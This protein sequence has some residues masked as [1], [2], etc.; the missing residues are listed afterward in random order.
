M[1]SL[2]LAK[3][4][5]RRGKNA[6]RRVAVRLRPV[7]NSLQQLKDRHRQLTDDLRLS[8]SWNR[9]AQ[10]EN[11]QDMEC[12]LQYAG[13]LRRVEQVMR[14]ITTVG[15]VLERQLRQEVESADGTEVEAA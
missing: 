1:D 3:D 10:N 6:F 12:V 13:L 9:P 7:V 15:V 14:K 5:P 2:Q 4:R 11:R 8:H